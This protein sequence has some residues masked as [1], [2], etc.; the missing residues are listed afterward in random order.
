VGSAKSS[1]QGFSR[2]A[3]PSRYDGK[4][5][6]QVPTVRDGYLGQR[7]PLQRTD[8]DSSLSA[9]HSDDKDGESD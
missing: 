3:S 1:K 9:H 6:V 4:P 5:R 8:T 7:L 2:S